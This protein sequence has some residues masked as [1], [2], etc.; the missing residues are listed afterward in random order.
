M[1]TELCPYC[2]QEFTRKSTLKRH[3]ENRPG[4]CFKLSVQYMETVIQ[5][6]QD[7]LIE[8]EKEIEEL[9]EQHE[10]VVNELV[11]STSVIKERKKILKNIASRGQIPNMHD[12]IPKADIPIQ[13]VR[14]ALHLIDEGDIFLFKKYFVE[15]LA[16]ENRCIRILD[17]A[18]DKCEYFDGHDWVV[19]P[20]MYVAEML[21]QDLEVKYRVVIKE[22][23]AELDE[24]DRT[25]NRWRE[26]TKYLNYAEYDTVTQKYE[27]ESYHYSL[28]TSG[29]ESHRKHFA[30]GIKK[31]L[32]DTKSKKN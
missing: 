11:N 10:K 16:P 4:K 20:L 2:G 25:Y 31:L 1:Q 24:V 21:L 23:K 27:N 22:K 5:K 14:L 28:I 6:K 7:D 26:E 12:V 18:R 17:F 32:S 30:N 19:V 8:K 3:L 13:D 29:D 9:K 15:G